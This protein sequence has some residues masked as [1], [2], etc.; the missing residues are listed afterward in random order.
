[1]ED[2]VLALIEGNA[3]I[4]KLKLIESIPELQ[5][6]HPRTMDHMLRGKGMRKWIARKRLKLLP[7]HTSAR[8]AWALEWNDWTVEQWRKYIWADECSVERS[9][10]AGAKWVLRKR[11]EDRYEAEAVDPCRYIIPFLNLIVIE[12]NIYIYTGQHEI[13]LLWYE[14]ISTGQH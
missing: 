5:E 14:G 11:G 12:S 7:R 6:I 10:E 13:Y 2:T 4:S 3:S 1:M 8:L 9:K